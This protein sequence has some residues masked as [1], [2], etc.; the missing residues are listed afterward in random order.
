MARSLVRLVAVSFAYDTSPQLIFEDLDLTFGAGWTGVVGANGAGKSTLLF[1]ALG[2][3]EPLRG[4]VSAPASRLYCPQRTDEQPADLHTMLRASEPLACRLRGELALQPDWAQRWDSLSHGERKRAQLAVALWQ[5]PQVLAVDEPTNHLDREAQAQVRQALRS[6]DG[7]GILVSH[8]RQ[9]LDGLCSQCVFVEPPHAV[10]RP[11]GYSRG[12]QQAELEQLSAQRERRAAK[13]LQRR[14][15]AERAVRN[16]QEAKA[17]RARSRHGI[18]KNDHDARGRANLARVTD[19]SSGKRVRQLDGRI[20]QAHE[21]LLEARVKKTYATGIA[22]NTARSTRNT[23]LNE[24]ATSLALCPDRSLVLPP[25]VVQPQ[26][27]IAL[28]GPNGTGKSTLMNWMCQRANVPPSRLC[29]LPQEL[30]AEQGAQ[31]LQAIR[32]LSHEQKGQLM[33]LVSRLGSRPQPLMTSASPSPGEVRKMLLALHVTQGA[34]LLLLDEP[35]NHLDLPSIECLEQALADSEAALVV[36]SHD[37]RF[38]AALTNRR[39]EIEPTDSGSVLRVC[40]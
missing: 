31:V 13:A 38:L 25:L 7:I 14:L 24:A 23:L 2:M 29:Y 16:T 8:D 12:R 20:Q 33:T 15:V 21:R 30:T 10:M 22:L 40:A 35:T 4:T 28:V 1:L 27:R 18:D 3:L 39:W 11:G 26:D 36:V 5:R 19:G 34:Q 32:Q 37:D 9:M 6:Y 17:E